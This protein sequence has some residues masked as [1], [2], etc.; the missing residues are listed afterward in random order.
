MI[1]EE[2]VKSGDRKDKFEK[3]LSLVSGGIYAFRQEVK[4]F[5]KE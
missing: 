4:K 5:F 1:S 2:S 3:K